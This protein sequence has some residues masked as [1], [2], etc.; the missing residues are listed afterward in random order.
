MQPNCFNCIDGVHHVQD[1]KAL[2]VTTHFQLLD[3]SHI[4]VAHHVQDL[5]APHA[6]DHF[7][8]LGS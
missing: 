3:A 2:H 6:T 4:D 1:L 8:L 5:K 7:Q